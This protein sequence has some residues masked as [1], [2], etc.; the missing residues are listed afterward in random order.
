[1]DKIIL[2][3][4]DY[5]FDASAQTISFANTISLNHILIITN[6]TDNIIIYNFACDGFGGTLSGKILTLEYN[7]SAMSDTDDLSI[8]IY[9]DNKDIESTK[10]L[11]LIRRQNDSQEEILA[12]LKIC[13]KYLRK[14]YN[15]E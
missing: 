3:S 12:E 4:D 5:S 1:M 15:P 8:M 9:K 10:L 14:I 13:S 7:T 6:I 2:T 11:D